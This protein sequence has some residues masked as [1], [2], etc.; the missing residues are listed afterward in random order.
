MRSSAVLLTVAVLL[1]GCATRPVPI[2]PVV[3]PPPVAAPAPSPPDA[4]PAPAAPVAVAVPAAPN[5]PE[6]LPRDLQTIFSTP[7]A[8]HAHWAVHVYSL[9]SA[10]SLYSLNAHQFMVPAS[11]QKLLTTA[12]AA[13]RLGWDFRFATKI[14]ATAPIE[15]DGT[16]VGD[17]VITSNGD[18]TINPRH[19]E[20][21]RIFDEWAKALQAKGLKI[22]SGQIV[23]DDNA[24]AE[25]GWGLGWAWD[26]LQDGYGAPVSALQYNENQ[27]TLQIGPGMA[28]GDR[29]I[30]SMTPLGSGLFIDHG[31]TTAAPNAAN[32]VR[33]AR[34]PGTSLLQVRGQIAVDAKPISV[35]AAVDNPTRLYVNAFREALAR[36]GIFVSGTPIDIDDLRTVLK[37]SD[38]TTLIDDR[39]PPLSE[40]IDV[41]NKWSRNIY[42]ETLLHAMAP[43]GAPATGAVGIKRLRETLSAWGIPA[44]SYLS[45]DG[46]GLSRYDFV[47]ANALTLLLTRIA[48]DPK[49]AELFRATLPVAGV[50]GSLAN[51]MK[52]TVAEG[53]V[54]AKTGTLS[55]VRA[56]SGYLTTLDGEPMVFS[57]LV[58]SYQIPTGEIDA[59]IDRALVRMVGR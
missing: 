41:T 44:D 37:L 18:P 1:N 21:W 52:G 38:A 55:H 27:V 23:G 12:V 36:H 42:A 54:A 9:R 35:N 51:R 58:N 19:P 45:R 46:S 33:L 39:S 11:N 15:A 24:F 31:V 59:I 34:V 56:L 29:A 7:A 2:A 25:P 57:I 40:I 49:H 17:L 16:L 53:R 8:A 13:E 6:R 48:A 5:T 47:S 26:N 30:I 14:V 3:A 4:A 28:P 43:P 20:R 32:G 10:K 50:S 22:V